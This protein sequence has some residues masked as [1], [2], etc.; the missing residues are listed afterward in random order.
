MPRF[1]GFPERP[2]YP[3]VKAYL[4]ELAK[5]IAEMVVDPIK[6][7]R[8][9]EQLKIYANLWKE[10]TT[11]EE[12]DRKGCWVLSMGRPECIF[13]IFSRSYKPLKDSEKEAK[14]LAGAYALCALIHD[15][16]LPHHDKINTDIIPK[17]AVEE[18]LSAPRN[19]LEGRILGNWNSGPDVR[20]I[21]LIEDF[22]NM[23]KVDLQEFCKSEEN[24]LTQVSIEREIKQAS[25]LSD[26]EFLDLT[27]KKFE[28]RAI[29]VLSKDE[30][31][32]DLNRQ[33]KGWFDAAV[34]RL[35]KLDFTENEFGLLK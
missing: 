8:F 30:T 11:F 3:S 15:R 14:R 27:A 26:K 33:L 29:K 34:E 12:A 13:N 22:F 9:R 31:W 25:K 35:R 5:D 24:K 2:Q 21:Y 6:M 19:T 7:E 18:T 16:Q 1:P 28:E 32:H 10:W 17:I 23:V 4:S 20:E